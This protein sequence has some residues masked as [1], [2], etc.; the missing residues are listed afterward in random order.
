MPETDESRDEALKRL[1]QRMDAF[2][3]RNARK[4]MRFESEGASA[5]YRVVAELIGGVLAGLGLGW[6]LDRLLGT[7]PFGLIGGVLIGT[8][9]AVFL[10]ARSA[11]KTSDAAMKANPAPAVPESD[12]DDN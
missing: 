6:L 4:P 12:A 5:G 8:G 9:A 1:D 10:I 3:V 11:G 7:S 2:T